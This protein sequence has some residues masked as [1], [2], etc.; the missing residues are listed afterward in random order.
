MYSINSS[1]DDFAF[2]LDE[3]TKE[4]YVSSNRDGGLGGDDI[5]AIKRIQPLNDVLV[6]GTVVD[7]KTGNPL[8]AASVTLYDDQGNKVLSKVTNSDGTVDFI[9]ETEKDA[10]LEVVMDGYV[11][12]KIKVSATTDE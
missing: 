1:A 8:N 9:I 7:S 3:E 4:G 5:Y 2:N 6:A 10:E 11:S 12:Q